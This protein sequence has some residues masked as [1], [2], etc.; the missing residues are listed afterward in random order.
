MSALST[1]AV[2]SPSAVPGLDDRP[3]GER[4]YRHPGDVL[5]LVV[6]GSATLLL[7][8]FID[9]AVAT[10]DGVR[11]DLG[12]AFT[13]VPGPARQL[14]L[15]IVQVGAVLV[16]VGVLTTLAVRGHWR[17]AGTVIASAAGGVAMY[18][19]VGTLLDEPERIAAA[20]GDDSWLI[21]ARFPSPTYLA[22]AFAA[23]T[24]GK[25]WL[26]RTWRRAA[27]GTA[28]ALAVT[29]AVAGSAGVPELALAVATGGLAGAAMLMVF[30]APNRRPTPAAIANALRTAGI[31]LNRLDLERAV[32]GRSQLYRTQT[33]DGAWFLKV[34]AQDSR[35]ADL[36]YRLY[37][38]LVLRDSGDG[39]PSSAIS[40]DVEHEAL[41][42]LLAERGGVACPAVKAVVPVADGSMV[43]AMT[44]SGRR[45]LADLGAND[46]G[47]DLLDAVWL[48]TVALHRAG[49][50]HRALRAA[51]VLVD[52]AGRPVTI[53]MGAGTAGAGRRAQAID[54]A[55]LLASLAVLVGPE[56]AVASAARVLA[57]DD[58]A[59]TMAY[60]QPLALSAATRRATTAAV[61]RD[62]RSRVRRD[63]GAGAGAAGTADPRAPPDRRHDRHPYRG[64]LHTPSATR[65]R[66]RQHRGAGLGQ[67]GM[68]RRSRRHVGTH[69]R[70]GGR[71]GCSAGCAKRFPSSRRCRSLWP[72]H[73]SI[74]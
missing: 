64:V 20:L 50:A 67:L 69:L 24:V 31:G 32:G 70:D 16:S 2:T 13:S 11:T 37:R 34:Y 1:V 10:S 43:L 15:A 49:L 65:R 17:R 52:E 41:M 21:S 57:A 40:R 48:Q 46:L 44:D 8:L 7:V 71:S 74:G 30:G 58:L 39:W 54:R 14:L 26:S 6:W 38:T 3:P 73:S 42:L 12:S 60:L 25:P 59:A 47:A 36:L 29:M 53:D 68:A 23:A 63:H 45:R 9:V 22:A 18:T 72:P 51:N 28:A 62:L 27:D 5:R 61:L 33:T 66:G 35:D 19:L 55:E 56:E 4:Y